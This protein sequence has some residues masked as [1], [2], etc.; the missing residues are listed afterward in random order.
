MFSIPVSFS[1][2]ALE[3]RNKDNALTLLTGCDS[4][5]EAYFVQLHSQTAQF[6]Q[7]SPDLPAKKQNT[8]V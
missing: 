6:K 5:K 3:L 2:T 8:N 4:L 7:T 1:F